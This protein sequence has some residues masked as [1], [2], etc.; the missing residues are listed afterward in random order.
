MKCICIK[1]KYKKIFLYLSP[2]VKECK[3]LL[4][5]PLRVTVVVVQWLVTV[6]KPALRVTFLW[7]PKYFLLK[8]MHIFGAISSFSLRDTTLNSSNKGH[9]K[10]KTN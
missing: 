6:E 3:S 4:T 2:W 5:H 8:S 1:Q 10:A 9:A 7:G